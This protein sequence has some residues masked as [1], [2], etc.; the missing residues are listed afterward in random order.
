MRPARSLAQIG[1][2]AAVL[3]VAG[4]LPAA[5]HAS[6]ATYSLP[7]VA[8]IQG[9]FP[10]NVVQPIDT[11][12]LCLMRLDLQGTEVQTRSFC[13]WSS[14]YNP[15]PSLPLTDFLPLY[16]HA[17]SG[18]YNPQTGIILLPY[19]PCSEVLPQAGFGV[20]IVIQVGKGGGAGTAAVIVTTDTSGPNYNCD[21]GVSSPPSA[22]TFT[23][24]DT[25]PAPT[26][27]EDGDGCTDYRELGP[28]PQSTGGLRDPFNPYD[29]YDVNH[30]GEVSTTLDVLQVSQ[31]WGVPAKYVWHKDRGVTLGPNAWNRTGPNKS[32]NI[33]ED[34]L[35]V[36][37][38]VGSP[39]L[40]HA[41]PAT[42]ALGPHPTT[43]SVKVTAAQAAPFAMSAGTTAGFPPSGSLLVDSET[44]DY[45][46]GSGQC[47]GFNPAAQF[48]V[49]GRGTGTPAGNAPAQHAVGAI[50]YPK[51]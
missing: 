40:G 2:A 9:A 50:V 36:A 17:A 1:V 35:A 30:D 25:P 4:I 6:S 33:T 22:L 45:N 12:R 51:P 11:N 46:Q 18:S 48:C 43:V 13:Y 28:G 14:G 44:L 27:D 10:G 38:Q 8:R 3:I 23:P 49:K 15:P 24:L 20:S 37:A 26:H 7:A 34:L 29:F 19:I 41:H 42:W 16:H 32:I 39:C 47:P 21:D 5:R 31:A